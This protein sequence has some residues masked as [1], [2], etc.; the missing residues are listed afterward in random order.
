MMNRLFRKF[1]QDIIPLGI[2]VALSGVLGLMLWGGVELKE[3]G[4]VH[5]APDLR[6]NEIAVDPPLEKLPSSYD[7]VALALKLNFTPVQGNE[8]QN[9]FQTATRDDGLRLEVSPGC[10][11]A[12]IV[13]SSRGPTAIVLPQCEFDSPFRL[14]LAVDEKGAF[15]GTANGEEIVGRRNLSKLIPQFN[16]VEYKNG[17]DGKRPFLGEVFEFDLQAKFFK[18]SNVFPLARPMVALVCIAGIL[19]VGIYVA[20]KRLVAAKTSEPDSCVL[21]F[22]LSY[23]FVNS[24]GLIGIL[25]G[26]SRYVYSSLIVRGQPENY[27]VWALNF[28]YPGKQQELVFEAGVWTGLLLYY[29]CL[30]LLRHKAG[31]LNSW[32]EERPINK[33]FLVAGWMFLIGGNA[34]I[35]SWFR[36]RNNAVISVTSLVL[37]LLWSV[38]AIA[39]FF[40]ELAKYW[41]RSVLQNS[42]EKVT[43]WAH[44]RGLTFVNIWGDFTRWVHSRGAVVTVIGLLSLICLHF[45]LIFSP[46]IW[47]DLKVIN[48]FLDI[49]EY[50][51]VDG[52]LVSNT[53]YINSHQLAGLNKYDPMRDLGRTPAPRPG[54]YV[55]LPKTSL[56]ASFINSSDESEALHERMRWAMS[57]DPYSTRDAME[58]ALKELSADQDRA[59]GYYYNDELQALVLNR[60]MTLGEYRELASIFPRD[61]YGDKITQLRQTSRIEYRRLRARIYT[62]EEKEFLA[63]NQ[64]EMH[65]QILNRWVIHHHNFV[66]GPI[67]E[68][69]KGRPLKDINAQYG[70]LNVVVMAT[71][72][73]WAGGISYA[74]YFPIWYSFWLIYFALFV[75]CSLLIFRDIFYVTLACVLAFGYI[76]MINFQILHLGPGLNPLRHFFDVPALAAFCL[77]LRK[78]RTGF[79]L[80]ALLCAVAGVLNNAQFGL[81]LAVALGGTLVIMAMID[82]ELVS[83][84]MVVI[85]GGA[86]A[87]LTIAMVLLISSPG[88]SKNSMLAYYLEGFVGPPIPFNRLLLTMIAVSAGYLSLVYFERTARDLKYI[89]LLLLLYS[90]GLF[91]Y[92]TWGGTPPHILNIAPILVLCVVGFLKVLLEGLAER[93]LQKPIIVSLIVISL[94]VVY[95][96]GSLAYYSAKQTFDKVFVDHKIYQWN[97]KTANFISTMDPQPFLDSVSLINEF[98][99][100]DF[101]IHIL[102][103]YDNFIPFLA[104]KYSAMP[105]SDV[106]WFLVTTKEVNLCIEQIMV[107]KPSYLFV[108]TDIGRSL[109]GDIMIGGYA[110]ESRMR[111]QRLNLLKTIYSA[112]Q[113]DYEP[114]KKGILLTAYKRKH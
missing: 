108:D 58:D 85:C 68:Y 88:S 21:R 19:C 89:V 44:S 48:E 45:V 92:Y 34:L 100:P 110:S 73:Q 112:I 39:P 15:R 55:Q 43:H 87:L 96:P 41:H 104:E 103:K 84:R 3:V 69:A 6:T 16:R 13:N 66:L 52:A 27:N 49:P 63:K 70:S 105:F 93:G 65:N 8:Y 107:S 26:L 101:A 91:L 30:F 40:F 29:L 83:F 81:A 72:L 20:R 76:I 14:E 23:W 59:T 53:D 11:V 64:F 24:V 77:F 106:P 113:D 79:L 22:L 114:V 9:L 82:R 47:G 71:L 75:G 109:N 25:Y 28:L 50:T 74:N 78:G 38:V 90:Q 95:I 7:V 99:G 33:R 32:R 31:G 111:V 12:L 80:V 4:H 60:E 36:G 37:L 56:L 2:A 61:E 97:L 17:F 10:D 18:H 94:C 102:S 42:V 46:F 98:S 86:A 5:I 54:M 57:G 67:S 62:S 1:S 35:F 51:Y